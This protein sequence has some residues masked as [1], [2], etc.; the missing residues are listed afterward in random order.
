MSF[1]RGLNGDAE[2]LF[3][4][5]WGYSCKTQKSENKVKYDFAHQPCTSQNYKPFWLE[6]NYKKAKVTITNQLASV[7][8]VQQKLLSML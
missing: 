2:Q 4:Q 8:K 3:G 1:G 5:R 6:G 7:V